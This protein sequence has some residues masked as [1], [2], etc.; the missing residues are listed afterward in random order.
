MTFAPPYDRNNV[1]ARILRGE[2]PAAKVWED[3]HVLAFMD[4]FP[5][6]D[7]HVLVISKTSIACTV[8]DVEPDVL[9]RLAAAARRTAQALV[10]A[11]DPEGVLIVQMNGAASGQTVFHL[12]YHVIP[13]WTDLP[14]KGHGQAPMAE[15]AT[16][17]T[18]AG[19]IAA[20]LD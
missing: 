18:L 3:D 6:S 10:R 5:Q 1:F 13:R 11:L 17:L 9:A 12:H 7:G 4:A 16:L 2:L 20:A 19:R 8:L 15:P 14:L